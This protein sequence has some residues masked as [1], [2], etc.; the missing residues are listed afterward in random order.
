[1]GKKYIFKELCGEDYSNC[2]GQKK[3]KKRDL[4]KN[5]LKKAWETRDFEIDKFWQRSMFFWGFITLISTGY[6][7]VVTGEFGQKAKDIYL[8]FY[9]ILLGIIFSVAWLLVIKG[10]KQWQEN[11]EQHI[12]QLENEIT[13]PLYKTI[14]FS[15]DKYYSVSKVNEILAWVVIITWGILFIRY[16][17]NNCN[18]INDII[19]YICKNDEEILFIFIPLLGTVFFIYR[20]IKKGKSFNGE[21]KKKLLKG[22]HGEFIL[23]EKREK[24]IAGK[25]E[26]MDQSVLSDKDQE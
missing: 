12:Y 9:L 1:M 24:V 13:G 15:G 5:A 8:D 3:I 10:S 19:N 22:K 25:H 26:S 14:Y 16:I 7:V 23:F 20:L 11:W 6:V 18:I 4:H 17:Y 2:F 21:L